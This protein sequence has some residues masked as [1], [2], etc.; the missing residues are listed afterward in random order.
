MV[1]ALRRA[2]GKGYRQRTWL[3]K[4][5]ACDAL[6]QRDDFQK[7]PADLA[8]LNRAEAA[9][10]EDVGTKSLAGPVRPGLTESTV[11][12]ERVILGCDW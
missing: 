12:A 6:H 10:D 11:Q 3:V 4:Y 5:P 8:A 7:L 2:V 1:A 9:K